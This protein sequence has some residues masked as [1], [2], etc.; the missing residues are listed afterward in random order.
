MPPTICAI[1]E[2]DKVNRPIQQKIRDLANDNDIWC[3]SIPSDLEVIQTFILS[4]DM[5]RKFI[6]MDI[7][8]FDDQYSPKVIKNLLHGLAWARN[9][10]MFT[11][12]DTIEV[13]NPR[14]KY[15]IAYII[16][17][18]KEYIEM[19]NPDTKEI[20]TTIDKILDINRELRD[21]MIV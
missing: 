17:G 11:T 9:I 20:H 6:F 2:S 10:L 3:F 13:F 1:F 21:I 5:K 19:I 12:I 16:S 4:K 18:D 15:S 8:N 14:L 7:N